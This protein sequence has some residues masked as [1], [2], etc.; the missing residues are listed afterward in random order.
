[1]KPVDKTILKEVANS[2]MFDMS[3]EEYDLLEEEFKT[4]LKQM[5]L[6]HEIKGVESLSPM[7]FPYV[8]YS[9]TMRKDV[10]GKTLTSE[11][12]LGNASDVIENQIRIPR[13]IK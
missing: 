6:I 2:L 5:S 3:E 12:A 13:V 9:S 4:I 1:M 10:P 8:C 7:T 11:E